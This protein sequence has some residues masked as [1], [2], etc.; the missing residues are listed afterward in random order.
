MLPIPE[1]GIRVNPPKGTAWEEAERAYEHDL[2]A[3]SPAWK[4][5]MAI[6]NSHCTFNDPDLVEE[7]IVVQ[8]KIKY[9]IKYHAACLEKIRECDNILNSHEVDTP[10]SRQ[11]K[12]RAKWQKTFL[13]NDVEMAGMKVWRLI[14][15]EV[16]LLVCIERCALFE[17][18]GDQETADDLRSRYDLPMADS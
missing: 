16:D 4:H 5:F 13:E 17:C 3:R 1:K 14:H 11:F 12:L 10:R 8:D 7:W 9:W 18:M 15:G 2:L 6:R